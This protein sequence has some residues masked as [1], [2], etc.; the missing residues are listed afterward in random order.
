MS[1]IDKLLDLLKEPAWSAP[2]WITAPSMQTEQA[3]I[4][5]SILTDGNPSLQIEIKSKSVSTLLT[6]QLEGLDAH[7]A[8]LIR[9]RDMLAAIKPKENR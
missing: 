2:T 9:H 7:I 4:H 8:E 3:A 6:Y 5:F 1:G